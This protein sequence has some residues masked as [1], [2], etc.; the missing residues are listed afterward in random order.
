V[1][2]LGRWKGVWEQSILGGLIFRTQRKAHDLQVIGK[3]SSRVGIRIYL[4][5]KVTG[6]SSLRNNSL[7]FQTVLGLEGRGQSL[8]NEISIRAQS[9]R[10]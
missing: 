10:L 1:R 3:V 6:M 8:I 9:L 2:V 4:V 5:C 7:S